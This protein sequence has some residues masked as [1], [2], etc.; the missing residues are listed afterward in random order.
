MRQWL[1]AGYF[2]GDLPISQVASGPFHQLS[3]WFPDLKFAFTPQPANGKDHNQAR[4]EEQ[5]KA[6]AAEEERLR[7]EAAEQERRAAEEARRA[8][9]ET[10]HR[11]AAAREAERQAA[12]SKL[13]EANGDGAANQSSNQ[14]KMM[15]GLQSSGQPP[16]KAEVADTI[17]PSK[18]KGNEKKG[19][20]GNKKAT[21]KGSAEAEAPAPAPQPTKP[22]PA[23]A[24]PAWGGAANAKQSTKKSMSEIQQEEARA[25]AMQAAKRGSMPQPSSGWANVAAGTSGW[26]GGAVR[27]GQAPSNAGAV[28][29]GRP[30]NHP[31]GAQTGANRKVAPLNQQQQRASTTTSSAPAEA[32]GAKIPPA[33]EKW[34]REKIHQINGS[35][36][37]TLIAFCMTLEDENDIHQYFSTYLGSSPQVTSFANEFINK[38]G[39]GSKQEEWETPGSAKKGRKK[40][41]GK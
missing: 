25:A 28:A 7:N 5:A 24:A 15:L 12:M 29:S 4:A 3:T 19:K 32:F 35:D 23:P 37:I 11:Q 22:A 1:E 33:L 39:L 2:K 36:D 10:A 6:R 13:A 40:K 38:R 30:T 8:A 18:P 16:S 9:A 21:Q 34:S 20:A 31:P 41:S 26:S 14:L 17:T 27:P